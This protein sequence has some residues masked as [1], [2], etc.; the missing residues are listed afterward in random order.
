MFPFW[1]DVSFPM[2]VQLVAATG[3]M[4]LWLV[5]IVTGRCSA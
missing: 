3:A 1:V 5:A 4:I 2:L